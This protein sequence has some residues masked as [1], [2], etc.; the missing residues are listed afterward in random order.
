MDYWM[1]STEKRK[2]NHEDAAMA[3]NYEKILMSIGML[4][5]NTEKANRQERLRLLS[6]V[7][8]HAPNETLKRF[9]QRKSKKGDMISV[10]EA[11][12]VQAREYAKQ[13]GP[14]THV[15][16]VGQI[17]WNELVASGKIE[18]TGDSSLNISAEKTNKETDQTTSSLES[19]VNAKE[20]QDGMLVQG[21]NFR[22]VEGDKTET[23]RAGKESQIV[24]ND[25]SKKVVTLEK[26]KAEGGKLEAAENR[27]TEGQLVTFKVT[28][29]N[30]QDGTAIGKGDGVTEGPKGVR[31]GAN[32]L[33]DGAKVMKDAPKGVTEGITGAADTKKDLVEPKATEAK[34]VPLKRKRRRLNNPEGKNSKDGGQVRKR[35]RTSLGTDA[36]EKGKKKIAGGKHGDKDIPGEKREKR[37]RTAFSNERKMIL[38][39]YFEK[40]IYVSKKVVEEISKELG[41]DKKRIENWFRNRRSKLKKDEGGKLKNNDENL[42]KKES[43]EKSDTEKGKGSA[44]KGD[45]EERNTPEVDS[46]SGLSSEEGSTMEGSTMERGAPSEGS[47]ME[48]SPINV[49]EPSH[50]IPSLEVKPERRNVDGS[51]GLAEKSSSVITTETSDKSK[52]ENE[53]NLGAIEGKTINR[54]VTKVTENK[55]DPPTSNRIVTES[56]TKHDL[57]KGVNNDISITTVA[58]TSSEISSRIDEP[59]SDQMNFKLTKVEESTSKQIATK[60]LEGRKG[61]SEMES[62]M[63]QEVLGNNE[64]KVDERAESRPNDKIESVDEQCSMDE[65]ITKPVPNRPLSIDLVKKGEK[66]RT[67]ENKT[68]KPSDELM[69]T[70]A[71]EYKDIYNGV[72]ENLN[73]QLPTATKVNGVISRDEKQNRMNEAVSQDPPDRFSGTNTLKMNEKEGRA[74]ENTADYYSDTT[75][76][77]NSLKTYEKQD[78]VYETTSDYPSK[79]TTYSKTDEY[80]KRTHD[81]HGAELQ[82]T[83]V[84]YED[85]SSGQEKSRDA[86]VVQSPEIKTPIFLPPTP[87]WE[88]IPVFKNSKQTGPYSIIS[89]ELS[90]SYSREVSIDDNEDNPA[91]V[92]PRIWSSEEEQVTYAL[93]E[94]ENYEME[95]GDVESKVQED[96]VIA[97]NNDPDFM[98]DL[99]ELMDIAKT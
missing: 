79:L 14:G 43:V 46:S 5:R 59:P 45:S 88:D 87:I 21:E 51:S 19:N 16:P 99:N 61:D 74:Y 78:R 34:P 29:R 63:V 13:F 73:N 60:Q 24:A 17:S 98:K 55:S 66:D 32:G 71:G 95:E 3:T 38:E 72:S 67:N 25:G 57:N 30:A 40:S 80:Q 69:K 91:R 54:T 53:N 22:S 52:N 1:L 82:Y 86:I 64:E 89:P 15:I 83:E 47:T 93:T 65:R 85:V 8:L 31:N 96:L 42:S 36:A 26:M 92:R 90:H 68:E 97:L 77:A 94:I 27:S 48:N 7:A 18:T 20:K 11:E 70:N 49:T 76:D 39:G 33:K 41:I 10:N 56:E 35:K 37:S 9:F 44:E 28:V 75:N 2:A 4:Y 84:G 81:S 62:L 58:S 12:I 6:T 50:G 23:D